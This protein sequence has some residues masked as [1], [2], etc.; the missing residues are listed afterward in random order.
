MKTYRLEVK[1]DDGPWESGMRLC[2]GQKIVFREACGE[3][4]GRVLAAAVRALGEARS[5]VAARFASNDHP[6][7]V[8]LYF[9]MDK[10]AEWSSAG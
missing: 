8:M 5:R 7:E 2:P 4:V 10:P 3:A 6:P 1:I 9:E